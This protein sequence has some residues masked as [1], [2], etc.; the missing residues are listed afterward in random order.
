MMNYCFDISSIHG[1]GSDSKEIK[2]LQEMA[3]SD[4]SQAEKV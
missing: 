4:I 1:L 3:K 2:E